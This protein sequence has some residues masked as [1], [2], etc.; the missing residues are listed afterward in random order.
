MPQEYD[1]VNPKAGGFGTAGVQSQAQPGMMQAGYPMQGGQNPGTEGFGQMPSQGV[2]QTGSIQTGAVQGRFQTGGFQSVPPQ[3]GGFQPVVPQSGGFQP[4]P[5]QGGFQPVPPQGSFQ[6]GGFQ[7]VP[8]QG[9][10][11]SGGFQSVPPQGGVQPGTPQHTGGF[12]TGGFQ[13]GGGGARQL[14]GSHPAQTPQSHLYAGPVDNPQEDAPAIP[15]PQTSRD[16]KRSGHGI[17]SRGNRPLIFLIVGLLLLGALIAALALFV[18][19]SSRSGYD[20]SRVLQAMYHQGLPVQDAFVFTPETDPDHLLGSDPSCTSK[21]GFT[22]RNLSGGGSV[23]ENGG[24]IEVFAS[25]EKAEERIAVLQSQSQQVSGRC[26]QVN[27]AVLRLSPNMENSQAVLY[28]T[29]LRT[30]FGK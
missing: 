1:Q 3:S 11:Q 4:I 26:S 13:S 5:P 25:Q 28:E 7:P 24:L 21:A 9:G 2:F 6:S 14:T 30:I 19:P 29:A 12:Q 22:D 23:L 27:R 16:G 10:F 17:A 18:F 8:P 20:A 15:V